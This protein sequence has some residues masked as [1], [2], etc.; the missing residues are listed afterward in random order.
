VV[1]VATTPELAAAFTVR[2]N[3][4]FGAG[5][6]FVAT[7]L[8]D[9]AFDCELSGGQS[10]GTTLKTLATTPEDVFALCGDYAPALQ[11]IRSFAQRLVKTDYQLTLEQGEELGA[12]S[13]LDRAGNERTLAPTD[14]RFDAAT[15]MLTVN[16][17]VLAPNDVSLQLRILRE[18]SLR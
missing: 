5:E 3:A 11:R 10:Y 18:C 6:Y 16:E 12:I 15:G 7:I 14:Y 2:A 17:G 9:G 13:L 8:H 4:S 1:N